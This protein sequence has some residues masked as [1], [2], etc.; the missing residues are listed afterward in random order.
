MGTLETMPCYL[1]RM[2]QHIEGPPETRGSIDTKLF[3]RLRGVK[4]MNQSAAIAL[5]MIVIE[6]T[7]NYLICALNYLTNK[8]LLKLC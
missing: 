5:P 4:K 1:Y 2:G 6:E 3:L 8:V 7:K